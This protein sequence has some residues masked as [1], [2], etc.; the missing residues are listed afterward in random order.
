[1]YITV[2]VGHRFGNGWNPRKSKT[3]TTKVVGLTF[4]LSRPKKF[5]LL[6]GAGEVPA[7]RRGIRGVKTLSQF[8][9][10]TRTTRVHAAVLHLKPVG[11]RCPLREEH[12]VVCDHLQEG[13]LPPC[14]ILCPVPVSLC[15]QIWPDGNW[16]WPGTIRPFGMSV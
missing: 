15:G 6:A 1:M 10:V 3:H 14:P 12:L 7:I 2:S 11:A 13:V 4:M 8:L 5:R 9:T 16:C